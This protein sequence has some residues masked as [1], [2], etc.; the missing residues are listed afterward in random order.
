MLRRLDE[1]ELGRMRQIEL[2]L[3]LLTSAHYTQLG[4]EEIIEQS[5]SIESMLQLL[6]ETVSYPNHSASL[7]SW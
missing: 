4:C 5:P 7:Q 6:A 1:R 3:N 2:S